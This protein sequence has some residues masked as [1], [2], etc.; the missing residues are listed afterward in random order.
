MP[1]WQGYCVCTPTPLWQFEKHGGME[2]SKKPKSS[3]RIAGTSA[4]PSALPPGC[5]AV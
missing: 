5:Q 2:R 4:Q 1:H 3:I